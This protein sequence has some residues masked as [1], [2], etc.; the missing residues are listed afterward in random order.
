M[1]S[2]VRPKVRNTYHGISK[3]GIFTI[4]QVKKLAILDM[5][6]PGGDGTRIPPFVFRDIDGSNGQDEYES[7]GRADGD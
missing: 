7:N 2:I 3:L 1:I 4:R 5:Y 6:L